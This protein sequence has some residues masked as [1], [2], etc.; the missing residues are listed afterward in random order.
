MGGGG[1]ALIP[2]LPANIW[3]TTGAAVQDVV[4]P[5]AVEEVSVD[6]NEPAS[7][8]VE[9]DIVPAVPAVPD[10][11]TAVP[12]ATEKTSFVLKTPP[13]PPI[14]SVVAAK[15]RGLS[16]LAVVVVVSGAACE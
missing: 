6:I 10:E 12:A 1:A 16:A 2:G 11:L 4:E 13:S 3:P 9:T 15:I 7:V 8:V 5:E 14:T